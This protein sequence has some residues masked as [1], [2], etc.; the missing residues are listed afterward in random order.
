MVIKKKKT[1]KKT[2]TNSKMKNWNIFHKFTP[3]YP[4][5]VSK[6]KEKKNRAVW[7]WKWMCVSANGRLDS[8]ACVYLSIPLLVRFFF[9]FLL[10]CLSIILSAYLLIY[11][12]PPLSVYLSN[13]LYIYLLFSQSYISTTPQNILSKYSSRKNNVSPN[14]LIFCM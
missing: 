9:F 4:D 7:A 8:C 14:V 11:L 6:K 12:S 3:F 13:H 10:I 1:S 2:P 5:I